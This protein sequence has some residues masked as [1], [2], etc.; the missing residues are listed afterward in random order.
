MPRVALI[1]AK[2][3]AEHALAEQFNNELRD[4]V[5]RREALMATIRTEGEAIL[6]RMTKEYSYEVKDASQDVFLT[7]EVR[8][9]GPIRIV[10]TWRNKSDYVEVVRKYGVVG[11][12][13]DEPVT[14]CSVVYYRVRG[15]LVHA[16]G[17]GSALLTSNKECSDTDWSLITSGLIPER[18]LKR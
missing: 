2:I 16:A 8:A 6:A 10:R 9:T 12:R 5:N 18:F 11:I 13:A 15:L 17:V 14:V 7:P 1:V 4:V 3:P